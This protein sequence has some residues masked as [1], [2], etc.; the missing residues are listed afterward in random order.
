M[1]L[2]RLSRGQKKIMW[3]WRAA[4]QPRGYDSD[5]YRRYKDAKHTFQ[6]EKKRAKHEHERGYV[7]E[8]KDAGEIDIIAFWCA[9]NKMKRKIKKK[10]MPIRDDTGKLL[11]DE[12]EI[13]KELE[14]Y[15]KVLLN[16][17]APHDFD[18]DHQA[19]IESEIQ[20][21]VP[22]NLTEGNAYTKVYTVGDIEKIG[23]T[24]NI[25][26]LVARWFTN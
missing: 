6:R 4:G 15:F 8:V 16:P 7:Q 13:N 5:V 14:S 17:K 1:E 25:G 24:Q 10:T 12:K 23:K 3:E 11:V 22:Q 2:T 26:H 20:N 9:Y 18:Q 21:N 19:W